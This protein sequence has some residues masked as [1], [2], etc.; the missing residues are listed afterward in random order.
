MF[1]ARQAGLA[2]LAYRAA[3]DRVALLRTPQRAQDEELVG[4]RLASCV[5]WK[6]RPHAMEHLFREAIN[7]ASWS[8]ST[9]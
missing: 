6:T 8:P 9:A 5:P 1:A 7:H 3:S 2:R 4:A